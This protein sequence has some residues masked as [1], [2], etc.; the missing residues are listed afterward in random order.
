M[1]SASSAYFFNFFLR[2]FQSK[3]K[4]PNE[5]SRCRNW[6]KHSLASKNGSEIA[7][8]SVGFVFYWGLKLT[9]VSVSIDKDV[10]APNFVNN[11][12]HI[13]VAF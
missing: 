5:F 3:K 10:M 12:R 6:C 8:S 4:L 11:V 1:N 9:L 2:L 13:V 7:F